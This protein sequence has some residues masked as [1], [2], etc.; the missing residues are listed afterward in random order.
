MKKERQDELLQTQNGQVSLSPEEEESPETIMGMDLSTWEDRSYD[1][2]ERSLQI[3][4][5]LDGEVKEEEEE[6]EHDRTTESS[7]TAN[8]EAPASV[9][10]SSV[11]VREKA[12]A[13]DEPS[14]KTTRSKRE[15]RRMRELEQAK[16][17][18]ELLKVRATSGGSSSPSEER[19][20]SVEFVPPA[21]PPLYSPQGTPDS[22]SSKGSFELLSMDDPPK[23]TEEVTDS[24]D[25]FSPPVSVAAVS[26]PVEEVISISPQPDELSQVEVSDAVGHSASQDQPMITGLSATHPPKIEN[27]LPTFYVPVSESSSVSR[28]LPD[29]PTH[30]T[31]AAFSANTTPATVKPLKERRESARRPVV[32]VISMQK[33]SPLSEEMSDMIRPSVEFYDS[34]AQTGEP[35]PGSAPVSQSPVPVSTVVP[36][37]D[38]AVIEKLVRLNEE[39]EERQR[40]QQQQNER[41]MMEQIRQQKEVLERQR[42]FFAQFERDMFEKHRGE[43]LQRIQQSRQG[44]QD[45]RRTTSIKQ[46]RPS[47]LLIERTSGLAPHSRTQSDSTAP[48]VQS[49]SDVDVQRS[50]P[51]PQLPPPPA[52]KERRKESQP[53][54]EGWV[55]KLT[56]E[57]KDGGVTR[58]RAAS[59]K[60]QNNQG[61][62]V[63]MTEKQGNIFFSPKDKV[64]F[65]Q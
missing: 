13:L 47:S 55:P 64:T 65:F 51:H 54:A 3:L 16:F 25:Y 60:V 31:E 61:T 40:N 57:S 45:V 9:S 63:G 24:E 28:R 10:T 43:A 27:Y 52:H 56:L 17:S 18:L 8:S 48:S 23:A 35:S 37:A 14:Q 29:E 5:N 19:R 53:V 34:S 42:L 44:G 46:V 36:K 32:V 4:S 62:A 26:E 7:F 2:R 58:V 11:V 20:W 30:N 22:Q 59:K 15:S 39:K 1:E 6:R 41:E 33:E 49:S 38:Q 50:A 21:T 12:G